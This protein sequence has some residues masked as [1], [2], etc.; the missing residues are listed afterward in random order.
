MS[1]SVSEK[2]QR[3]FSAYDMKVLDKVKYKGF[4]I[5]AGFGGPKYAYTNEI[6]KEEFPVGYY[7]GLWHITQNGMAGDET[8]FFGFTQYYDALDYIK[9]G[10]TK[11]EYEAQIENELVST[12]MLHIDD[13]INVAYE[14]QA[15]DKRIIIA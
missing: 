9:R 3:H 8:E 15:K 7:D 1:F 13:F 10:L 4:N 5:Y 2:I 14:K 11:E 12:A 6:T